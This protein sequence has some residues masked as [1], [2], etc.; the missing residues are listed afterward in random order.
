M[1]AE[2]PVESVTYGDFVEYRSSKWLISMFRILIF[3]FIDTIMAGMYFAD[4][5]ECEAY[6]NIHDCLEPASVDFIN[7]LCVWDKYERTCHFSPPTSN[8]FGLVFI[9]AVISIGSVP[10]DKL[11]CFMIERCKDAAEDMATDARYYETEYKD[12]KNKLN[13]F[14]Q[15]I[16]DGHKKIFDQSWQNLHKIRNADCHDRWQY[17]LIKLQ[18]PIGT[19]FRGARLRLMQSEIDNVTPARELDNWKGYYETQ[20]FLHGNRDGYLK[21]L[22]ERA[23]KES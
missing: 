1:V 9:T 11:C 23:E 12:A 4:D 19:M 14:G 18:T 2:E 5:G 17:D 3:I 15:D 7:T 13:M 8:F 21:E 20:E 16:D 6:E 22:L 10:F